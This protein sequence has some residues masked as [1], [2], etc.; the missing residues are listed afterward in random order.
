MYTRRVVSCGEVYG[1]ILEKG[2]WVLKGK[3][4]AGTGLARE[5]YIYR[6]DKGGMGIGISGESIQE[7]TCPA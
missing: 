6:N 3:Y 1:K 7:G 4:R 2:L 5:E